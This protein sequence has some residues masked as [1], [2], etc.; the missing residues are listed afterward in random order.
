MPC[1][2]PQLAIPLPGRTRNG[3]TP[4][5]FIGR[6]TD[7]LLNT[8]FSGDPRL[9]GF[10]IMPCRQCI[11]CRLEKS[12]QTATRL[13]HETKF[14][15]GSIF[16]TLTYDPEH[17]PKNGSL[18]RTDF[19]GFLKRLRARCD[20]EA[21]GKI[22]AFG[23]GE[24]GC[25]SPKGCINPKCSHD[26]R[27]H[28][29]AIL[30]GPY[31]CDSSDPLRSEEEPSRSGGRQFTHSDIAD[32]WGLGMHRFSA[33]TFE[34]AAYVAR[35]HLKKISGPLAPSHYGDRV[36]EFVSFGKGIG[37][38]HF[39]DWGHDIYPS[40]HV[41]LP[42]RGAFLPPPYY[43]RLLEKT[44]PVL[45]EEI[46]K[47]RQQAQEQMTHRHQ[48]LDATNESLREEEV[49]IIVTEQTLKRGAQ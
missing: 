30:Y 32:S 37:R 33:V 12:R 45:Y 49:R 23:V 24:Y 34:S 41:V 27:A 38:Q 1:Y 48:L 46:K 21:K 22:K 14:H 42:G 2:R 47:K 5:K 8:A 9:R 35:Y 13:M 11:G 16:L 10:K 7:A 28:Y 43:D 17:Y 40:D 19:T 15:P 25:D 44:D 6:A 36:P 20:Y 31:D 3:K 18:I 26:A 4:Y 29:H 39:E